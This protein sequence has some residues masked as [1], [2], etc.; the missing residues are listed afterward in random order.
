MTD[1]NL[2][3]GDKFILDRF[4]L[5]QMA[6]PFLFGIMSFTVI[7]VAGNLLFRLA[8]LVIQRGVSMPL[9]LRLFVYSLP[10]VVAMTIPMSCLL[11]ALLGFGNMSANSELVAL[12]SAGIS[13]GR[14][15]RPLVWAGVLISLVTFAINET[16]VPLSQRAAA[17]LMR[18]EIYRQTP[19]VFKDNVFIRDISSGTLNRILYIKEILPRTG[20]MSDILVQEFENGHVSRVISAPK[21]EW[22]DGLW[23]LLDGQVFE[24]RDDGKVDMLF[25]FDRQKLNLDMQP[26]EID[27]DAADPEEMNLRELYMMMRN[28]DKQGNNAGAL[29]MMFH[30]RVAVPW[31]SVVLVLVGASVGSRPQ[32]SSSSMGFGLSVVIVFCYYV[33]MSFCKSLGEADFMPGLLAAWMPNA[34]FLI[35]GTILIRRANRLG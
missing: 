26:E 27:A 30:L 22:T 3:V 14:I 12:K 2:S 21:G 25:R 9:V 24:V 32:R 20:K 10:G 11:A 18:Y 4:I 19:P 5:G 6:S 15:V 31:A 17:N 34:V 13:F 28:A 8:D 35:V 7:L 29:R 23:W 16:I 1:K 33:I